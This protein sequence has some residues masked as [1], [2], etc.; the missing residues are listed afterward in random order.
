MEKKY[1]VS[2]EWIQRHGALY[3]L[4]MSR[5]NADELGEVTY[6]GSA[7]KGKILKAG[8]PV[9]GLEAVKAAMDFYS[10]VDGVVVATNPLLIEQPQLV[11]EKPLDEGWLVEVELEK[12][13]QLEG[14]LSEEEYLKSQ[15]ENNA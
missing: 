15:G 3:R 12:V 9:L 13:S 11:N 14:L 4:G 5:L 8:E 2:G 10:P 6:V 7:E 1:S